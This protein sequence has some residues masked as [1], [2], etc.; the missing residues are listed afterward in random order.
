MLLQQFVER[1]RTGRTPSTQA[2]AETLRAIAEREP[3]LR[4]WAH[5]AP[6]ETLLTQAGAVDTSLPLAGVPFGVKDIIDVAGMPTR[7]G[8]SV[9]PADPRPYDAACVDML[10][11]AGAI[12]VGKTVTAEFA[13]KAPGPT[14]NPHDPGHTPGGSSSGSAAAVAAGMVPLALGT[15]TGGSMIRP[16]AYCGV[17]GFKP[18]FGLV[19]RDGMKITC[20]SLDVIGWYAATVEDVTYAARVLLPDP[21]C[22]VAPSGPMRVVI[23]PG[24][25]VA[26]VQPEAE[27]AL[28]QA[29]EALR[30][31]GHEI[32]IMDSFTQAQR[33]LAAHATIM[34]YELSRNIAPVARVHSEGLSDSLTST[35][36]RGLRIDAATYRE[37]RQFQAEM[38][39]GWCA[40]LGDAD[41]VMTASAPGAAPAGLAS[42]GDGVFNKIWS[43]LGWPCLHLP[44]MVKPG[45]NLPVGVQLIGR[46]GQDIQFL[47][48]AALVRDVL[49]EQGQPRQIA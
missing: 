48:I 23:I 3:Q 30:Q 4:A 42:T 45:T 29:T 18:S 14:V 8:S 21:A 17:V 38:Q 20:E 32:R 6:T 46:F 49:R 44:F 16:A 12:P 2:I 1:F 36:S 33:I 41:L 13:Y 39:Q 24:A 19:P 15:Q 27:Q 9:T 35:I 10:R 43:V 28:R 40:L 11:R 25:A 34:E 22:A 37:A 26:P 31:A 7:Y 5:V 47:S